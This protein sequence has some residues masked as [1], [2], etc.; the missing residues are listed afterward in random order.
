V[1]RREED[2][3]LEDSEMS[4]ADLMRA[5]QIQKRLRTAE[6][7]TDVEIEADAVVQTNHPVVPYKAAPR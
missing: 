6:A 2:E 3:N 7:E 1:I 4:T 5:L